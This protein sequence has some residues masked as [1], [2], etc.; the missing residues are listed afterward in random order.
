VGGIPPE[1]KRPVS[2]P[3]LTGLNHCT[4]FE[5]ATGIEPA[6]FSLGS[7]AETPVGTVENARVGPM[8]G[9]TGSAGGA[10]EALANLARETLTAVDEGR[11]AA[12]LVRALALATL[13]TLPPG[14]SLWLRAAELLETHPQRLRRAVLLAGEVIEAVCVS[15]EGEPDAT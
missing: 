4:F 13:A 11:P 10:L 5:R 12:D 14:A 3:R 7:G 1:R 15:S 9:V 6:T 8:L 2:L